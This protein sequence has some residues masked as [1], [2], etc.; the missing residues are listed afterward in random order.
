MR[1][2]F[3]LIRDTRLASKR[4]HLVTC[5]AY[6]RR[7]L[8]DAGI[9]PG[10]VSV[11]HPVPPEDPSEPPPPPNEQVVSF[12]GQVIRGKGLD[13]LLRAIR[14]APDVHVLV[15]GEGNDMPYVERL[16]EKWGLANRVSMLGA[17]PPDKVNGVY[18]RSRI[19]VVP[20]RWPEPF[21]MV[22]VEAMRR[23]R[24]VIAAWHGGI[25]EW[26]DHGTTGLGF[27]PGDTDD[28]AFALRHA[29]TGWKYEGLAQAARTKMRSQFRF[30][31]MLDQIGNLLRRVSH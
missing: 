7:T 3:Q 9:Q 31:Q 22:G 29:M 19:V 28:L 16:I 1:N 6:L 11:V 24:P 10:R 8:L 30:S 14:S 23:G 20:S 27:G 21:G 4:A 26:L 5:S 18:D 17:L 13:I 2:P 25:P 15:A 12:V